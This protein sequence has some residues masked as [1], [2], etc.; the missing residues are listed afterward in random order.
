LD[1]AFSLGLEG[2]G[3][4]TSRGLGRLSLRLSERRG[5]GMNF[6]RL[7]LSLNLSLNLR[8]RAHWKRSGGSTLDSF[9]V[10]CLD[11]KAFQLNLANIL[12]TCHIIIPAVLHQ[13]TVLLAILLLDPK[14]NQKWEQI[15][16][17]VNLANLVGWGR[18]GA[19]PSLLRQ[20][21]TAPSS[22]GRKHER[23]AGFRLAPLQRGE[24]VGCG[25]HWHRLYGR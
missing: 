8:R 15:P 13:P 1:G 3:D 24:I 12:N 17:L 14:L 22:V 7:G 23:G 20:V 18:V 19:P 9:C 25:A 4:F 16:T 6:I 2:L 10:A 11:A 21:R 5:G